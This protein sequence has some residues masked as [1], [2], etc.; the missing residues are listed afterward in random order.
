MSSERTPQFQ[1][2][3]RCDGH[4]ACWDY[5]CAYEHGLG[6]L[7]GAQSI[8]NHVTVTDEGVIEQKPINGNESAAE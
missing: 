3:E 6:H 5:G 2:C 1:P 8:K 4:D 7:V